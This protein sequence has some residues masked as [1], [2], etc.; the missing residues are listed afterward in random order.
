M[1]LP[2][3]SGYVACLSEKYR[4]GVNK[5]REDCFLDHAYDYSRAANLLAELDAV[6]KPQIGHIRGPYLISSLVPIDAIKR[7][8]QLVYLQQ[9]LSDTPDSLMELH[10]NVLEQEAASPATSGRRWFDAVALRLRDRIGAAAPGI[11]NVTATIALIWG[12]NQ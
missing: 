11:E 2:V 10:V 5:D 1:F 12:K 9:D 8:S 6:S 3:N 7:S 4:I